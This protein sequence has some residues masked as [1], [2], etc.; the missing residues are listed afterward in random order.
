MHT[1][2]AE[3]FERAP[4]EEEQK[5]REQILKSHTAAVKTQNLIV[6]ETKEEYALRTN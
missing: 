2:E 6:E 5:G 1:E 4:V 3:P